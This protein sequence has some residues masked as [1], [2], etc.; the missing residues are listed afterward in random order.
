[1]SLS[2]RDKNWQKPKILITGNRIIMINYIEF[3]H[4]QQIERIKQISITSLKIN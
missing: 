1:M 2:L 4:M 3:N